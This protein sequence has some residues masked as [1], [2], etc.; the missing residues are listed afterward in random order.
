MPLFITGEANVQKLWGGY[1][2]VALEIET[3]RK[4]IAGFA[5]QHT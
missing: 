4:T 1:G 5:A 3:P 2:T